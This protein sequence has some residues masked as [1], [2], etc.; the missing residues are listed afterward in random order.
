MK[1]HNLK[2]LY[3]K[4]CP[5]IFQEFGKTLDSLRAVPVIK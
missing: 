2:A 4:T 5:K 3:T 1:P